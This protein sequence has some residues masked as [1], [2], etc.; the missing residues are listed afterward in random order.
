MKPLSLFAFCLAAF[1]QALIPAPPHS[2]CCVGSECTGSTLTACDI[3]TVA[4]ITGTAPVI[5]IQP[6]IPAPPS[7]PANEFIATFASYQAYS[8][9]SVTGGLAYAYQLSPNSVSTFA[10]HSYMALEYNVW[11]LSLK[12]FQLQSVAR[13][14][15]C[16]QVLDW[17][18]HLFTCGQLSMATAGAGSSVQGG[19]A[20]TLLAD[21][22]IGKTKWGLAFE[23]VGMKSA[24][25]DPGIAYEVGLRRAR[26]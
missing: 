26:R 12:P 6:P 22:Q 18:V 16:Q 11:P 23:I 3:Q 17:P 14:G 10:Q 19:V 5:Q 4:P 2:G 9:P 7:T 20:G 25:S 8:H 24:L 21:W 13:G 1:G 15:V